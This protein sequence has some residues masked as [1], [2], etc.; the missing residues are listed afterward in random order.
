MSAIGRLEVCIRA[1]SR[2]VSAGEGTA[3]DSQMERRVRPPDD[4]GAV[5]SAPNGAAVP[6][7]DWAEEA[8]SVPWLREFTRTTGG[9][10]RSG[11]VCQVVWEP[12]ATEL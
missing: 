1:T 6:A 5:H 11:A 7:A 8:P 10:V 2:T 3:V 9:M 4:G 12:S